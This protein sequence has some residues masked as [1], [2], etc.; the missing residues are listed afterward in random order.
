MFV[1]SFMIHESSIIPHFSSLEIIIIIFIIIITIYF[2]LKSDR[3]I[4][5]GPPGYLSFYCRF[6]S[7]SR[8]TLHIQHVIE[9]V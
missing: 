8:F 5:L 7:V 9:R 4:F 1:D 3:V 6:V 2:I